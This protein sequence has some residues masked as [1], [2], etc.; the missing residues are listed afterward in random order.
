MINH[1]KSQIDQIIK[2]NINNIGPQKL[3]TNLETLYSKKDKQ[4]KI[5]IKDYNGACGNHDLDSSAFN[6]TVEVNGM[7]V[8]ISKELSSILINNGGHQMKIP[9]SLDEQEQVKSI[10]DKTINIII[11]NK[12]KKEKE[13]KENSI[14]GQNDEE[15]KNEFA[16]NG[17]KDITI[18]RSIVKKYIPTNGNN[19][20][21]K[22]DETE[23]LVDEITLPGIDKDNFMKN[24]YDL[25]FDENK[26]KKQ[27]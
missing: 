24:Y 15:I 27:Y 23:T 21:Q 20:Y 19:Y 4:T 7:S 2:T 9:I 14:G 1:I 12:I 5:T 10:I 18:N 6:A 16:K 3:I 26:I 22:Q 17:I 11:P 25:L 8:D 13:L